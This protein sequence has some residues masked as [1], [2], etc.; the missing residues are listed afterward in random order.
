MDFLKSCVSYILVPLILLGLLVVATL[1]LLIEKAHLT[2]EA[3]PEPGIALGNGTVTPL[4]V[5]EWWPYY[6]GGAGVDRVIT[7][8]GWSLRVST[9]GDGGWYGARAAFPATDL[10][11]DS[12]RFS[13]RAHN[14][15]E[16]ERVMVLF[17]S[18][19]EFTDYYGINLK[20]YFARPVSGEW[21]EVILDPSEF[22]AIE[23]APTWSSVN[24][25]A[26]RVVPVPGVSTRVWFDEF[27]TVSE[28]ERVAMVSHTFDDG[29]ASVMDAAAIMDLYGQRGTAFIIP[30][31]LETEGYLTQA[32]VDE[33]A[34]QGWD[35]S[36]HGKDNLTE[37][38][39]PDVDTHLAAMYA[40]L[41]SNGYDGREHFAYPNGAY[42]ESVQSQVLEYFTSARSIDGFHQPPELILPQNVN[43]ITVSSS[44]PVTDVIAEIDRARETGTWLILVWHDFTPEPE[45]DVEYHI[46]DFEF[47]VE[48]LAAQEDIE[49]LPYSEAFSRLTAEPTDD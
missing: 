31:F 36:G 11:D 4:G 26:V 9:A 37:L 15:D 39:P 21:I 38:V 22:E 16:V 14:W 24:E 12:I 40:Y 1:W 25:V 35:I 10:S 45:R 44:T 46:S 47:V 6:G 34:N 33:L 41:E 8:D 19:S 43:A 28:H 13:F 20:N 48:H 32:E 29:F 2:P 42:T 30:E 27:G 49:V 23:G 7:Q 5:T 18:D 3:P 17:A